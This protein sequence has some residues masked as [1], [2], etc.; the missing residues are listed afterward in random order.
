M[1]SALDIPKHLMSADK[2]D[3]FIGWVKAL[4]VEIWIK[5]GL[6]KIWR[7]TMKIELDGFDYTKMGL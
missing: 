2:K 6:V 4:P 3:E 5:R 1:P 7:E